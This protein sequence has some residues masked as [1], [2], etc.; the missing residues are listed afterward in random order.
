MS[1]RSLC[2]SV[3][4]PN[5]WLS[6]PKALPLRRTQKEKRN[7]ATLSMSLCSSLHL[8]CRGSFIA[9]SSL[10]FIERGFCAKWL[11]PIGFRIFLFAHQEIK[12]K[13]DGQH[14]MDGHKAEADLK[15]WF[16]CIHVVPIRTL[17]E[18]GCRT[19]GSTELAKAERALANTSSVNK[20]QFDSVTFLKISTS[21]SLIKNT[22][23]LLVISRRT[24]GGPIH[25]V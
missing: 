12:Y 4:V 8:F 11:A 22:S 19:Q 21:F 10:P 7:I 25:H 24:A 13:A 3:V 14:T 15:V 18:T 23:P 6:M 1:P 16:I 20:W 9:K 2:R 5:R 17:Y